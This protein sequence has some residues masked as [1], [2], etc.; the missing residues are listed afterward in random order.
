MGSYDDAALGLNDAVSDSFYYV[1][2]LVCSFIHR[3]VL[4][5]V[6]S[7]FIV[8]KLDSSLSCDVHE[9]VQIKVG[10]LEGNRKQPT[11]KELVDDPL[12]NFR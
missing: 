3:F 9:N 4:S 10:T 1:Y 12:L 6:F 8:I 11:L 2:R 7:T 5:S